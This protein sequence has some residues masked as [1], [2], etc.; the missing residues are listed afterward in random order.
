VQR[1]QQ[2]FVLR[3]DKPE[4]ARLGLDRRSEQRAQEAAA[5]AGIGPKTRHFDLENG[6]MLR[7]FVSGRSWTVSDL[8][9][10]ANVQRLAHLLRAVHRL[11]AASVGRYD[12]AGAARR[13]A[14]ELGT[15]RAWALSSEVEACS[16]RIAGF[17]PP[18]RLC[19]ND[20]VCQNIIDGERLMLIDWEYAGL[21]DPFFDLAVVIRHHGLGGES[22]SAFHESYLGR[23]AREEESVRLETQQALY[24]ALLDLWLL[25]TE[26]A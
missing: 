3:L 19:H 21:G 24:Q 25:R 11:P 13:Y 5:G 22:A 12:P 23:P 10:P 26:P 2:R 16:D 8:E 7:C 9:N 4:A 14:R 1:D 20:L 6:V 15:P 17:A 18:G